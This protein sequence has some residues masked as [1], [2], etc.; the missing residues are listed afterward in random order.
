MA[1]KHRLQHHN[2][3]I[4]L[5]GVQPACSKRQRTSD[6]SKFWSLREQTKA[7]HSL[8]YTVLWTQEQKALNNPANSC[9]ETRYNSGS[10]SSV[11]D[12]FSSAMRIK[13]LL[14][15]TGTVSHEGHEYL[16]CKQSRKYSG[17][18]QISLIKASM[19]LETRKALQ[20]PYWMNKNR[21]SLWI[22]VA[23]QSKA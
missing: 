22:R 7:S 2:A 9:S 19:A 5:D 4:L 23:S 20:R 3:W 15:Y 8:A 10:R 14:K 21:Q 12:K 13:Q 11:T 1:R 16:G 17:A 18:S 6:N